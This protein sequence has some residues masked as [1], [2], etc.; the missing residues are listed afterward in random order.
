MSKNIQSTSAD[1]AGSVLN[2]VKNAIPGY[3]DIEDGVDTLRNDVSKVRDDANALAGNIRDAA[4]GTVKK[5]TDYV[6]SRVDDVKQAGADVMDKVSSL[7][8][9]PVR[10]AAFAILALCAI[11]YIFGRT[12]S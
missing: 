2:G 5:G 12:K 8:Q 9:T 3:G 11:S 6:Q 4:T 10:K 1:K 7:P